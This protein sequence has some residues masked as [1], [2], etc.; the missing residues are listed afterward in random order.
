[1]N[2]NLLNAIREVTATFPRMRFVQ[3]LDSALYNHFQT[4]EWPNHAYYMSDDDLAK[5]LREFVKLP[6][7]GGKS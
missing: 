1:M 4:P 7:H 3:L 5:A 6:I 2:N